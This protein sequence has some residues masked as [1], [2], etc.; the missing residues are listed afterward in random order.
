M[1]SE[2][3]KNDYYYYLQFRQKL[4]QPY[5]NTAFVIKAKLEFLFEPEGPLPE[6]K[7]LIYSVKF[8]ITTP[9]FYLVI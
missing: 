3:I 8:Y 6:R 5:L 1:V 4:Q 9:L 7:F 2:W